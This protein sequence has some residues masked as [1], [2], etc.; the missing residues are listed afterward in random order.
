[1]EILNIQFINKKIDV[2]KLE[3]DELYYAYKKREIKREINTKAERRMIIFNV[4]KPIKDKR[5]LKM[6]FFLQIGFTDI[7]IIPETRMSRNDIEACI[8]PFFQSS[9]IFKLISPR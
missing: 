4:S 8:F 9:Q 7:L 2:E 1:M 5:V 6:I 3:K